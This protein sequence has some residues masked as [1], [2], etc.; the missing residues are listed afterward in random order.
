VL[1]IVWDTVRADH[2]SAYGH[3]RPTTPFLEAWSRR[4][5]KFENCISVANTTLPAH[6]SMFTGSMPSQ[7]GAHNS[8]RTFGPG[9]VTLAEIL[10]EAGYR[11]FLYSANPYVS[12]WTG[13]DQ[14]FE[15]AE[16]PWQR[17]L[18]PESM[19]LMYE[20]L[21]HRMD[22]E[23]I[24]RK[25][26][27][28]NARRWLF[29]NIGELAERRTLRFLESLGKGERFFVF[30]NYMEAHSPLA[31]SPDSVRRVEAPGA[32]HGEV[33]EDFPWDDV[34]AYTFGVRELSP[35]QLAGVSLLYDAAIL[36]LDDHFRSLWQA[37]EQGGYLENTLVI[38]TSDHGQHL[39]EHHLLD[40]QYSL[41]EPLLRVPLFLYH[42]S[43]IEAGRVDAPVTNLDLYPTVL[44]FLGLGDEGP[45]S[46][47][48]VDLLAPAESRA[49]LAE[50][51][52]AP[53]FPVDSARR[54][55]PD[56]DPSPRLRT[57]R[58]VIEGRQ[59][60]IWASD[61]RHE[62]YDLGKDPGERHN[63]LD[64]RPEAAGRFED[65]LVRELGPAPI[66]RPPESVEPPALDDGMRTMLEALGYVESDPGD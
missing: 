7:H 10:R 64:S 34:W 20:K 53:D 9:Q 27:E 41:Y 63:L 32:G 29:K 58:A 19:P 11:T 38:L 46:S 28:S 15:L 55:A 36:E 23:T 45:R 49:R 25:V 22:P 31:P 48:G 24:D 62:L 60:F 61:G 57:L 40:H 14:G 1:W 2:L 35:G 33:P 43:R 5:R 4:T 6:A 56:L 8:N 26:A 21:A 30:L 16:Y 66:T 54:V 18:E 44:R 51:P 47:C 13:T 65:I 17:K 12:Q 52:D 42:P 50:C 39:G 59:K 37:L 3:R